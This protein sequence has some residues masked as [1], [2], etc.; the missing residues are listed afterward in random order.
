MSKAG[1]SNILLTIA[2][3]GSG[4]HGWQK[5]PSVRT[6]QGVIE[7]ALE[8]ITGKT[9]QVEGTSRTDAGVHAVG[10]CATIRGD[11]GIPTERISLA[12]NNLLYDASILSAVEKPENFHA[13]TDAIGK[14][15]IYRFAFAPP[16]SAAV[17]LRHYACILKDKPNTGMMLEAAKYI[18]GTHDFA[19][20]QASGGAP[21][22]TTVRTIFGIEIRETKKNDIAG[23]PYEEIEIA[24]TG[25]GFLYNMV[26]IIAGTLA[27]VGF[28]K[29]RP[30][31]IKDIISSK[32]RARAGATAPPQGLYLTKVYFDRASLMAYTRGDS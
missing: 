32:D 22:E 21:R 11:F 13:C 3:D 27:S 14:T 17:F 24:V 31:E 19:C 26:R 1:M 28:G 5:Q 30:E 12:V 2:Y 9:I 20:F 10:Q 23:N 15:Y 6:V 16:G 7:E 25:D 8:K 29:I 4:F 18:W